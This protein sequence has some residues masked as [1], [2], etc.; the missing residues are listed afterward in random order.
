MTQTVE[1]KVSA[2]GTI[3]HTIPETPKLSEEDTALL[4]QGVNQ[5]ITGMSTNPM[6]PVTSQAISNQSSTTNET[7]VSIG[8][9]KVETQSTDAAGIAKD[10]NNAWRSEVQDAGQQ[11]GTGWDK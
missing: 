6:N 8:E 7:N 1:R 3:E 2:D 11:H 5:H 4:V 9:I 10:A